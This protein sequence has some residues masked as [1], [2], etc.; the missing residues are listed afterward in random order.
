MIDPSCSWKPVQVKCEA[1]I[2][3]DPDGRINKRFKSTSP[4]QMILPNVM[5]MIAQLGPGTSSYHN[6][7]QQIN[8]NTQSNSPGTKHTPEHLSNRTQQSVAMCFH[9]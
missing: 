6:N 2:K 1:H 3:E 7:P 4:S 5:D 9:R 8:N